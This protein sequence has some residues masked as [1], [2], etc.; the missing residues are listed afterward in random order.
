MSAD[1]A[2][3]AWILDVAEDVTAFRR[4]EAAIAKMTAHGSDVDERF[5][6]STL[7]DAMCEQ[8]EDVWDNALWNLRW[9]QLDSLLAKEGK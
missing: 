6:S 9:S 4:D 7:Y 8:G 1:P 3:P 2:T 5:R